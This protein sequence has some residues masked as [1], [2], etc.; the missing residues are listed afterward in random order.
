MAVIWHHTPGNAA[1]WD[2][3]QL[4]RRGHVGVDFFFVLSGFLITTLLLREEG[5]NG[6]I[7]L[8]GFYLR[9]A[10]RIL[11]V[12]FLVV[13][14]AAFNDIILNGERDK[15]EILPY[16][17]LFL[18]N[19]IRGEDITFLAP[20]W[21]LSVEEQYYLIW[22]LLLILLPKRAIV[23]ALIILITWNV[24]SALGLFNLIGVSGISAGRLYFAIGGATYA[25]ILLGSLAAVVLHSRSGFERL[26]PLTSSRLAPWVL[27]VALI[28]SLEFLPPVLEGWPNLIVHGLMTLM[29]V[30]VVVREDNGM[31]TLLRLRPIV[32]IGQISY[33]LYLYHS[34]A[35][36]V[37]APILFDQGIT[38]M[39][40]HLIAFFGLS[41]LVSEISFRT[42]EKWFLDMR[43]KARPA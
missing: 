8:S 10:L 14:A 28:L 25:P 20:T 30:S 11:P 29:L 21:S 16:Y 27:F 18:A 34:F 9:R 13:T 1:Y 36:G 15:I 43:H 32:R 37:T 4:V 39:W 31:N 33:G 42:Y 38:S 40:I 5:Q 3:A 12:Y 17:Y 26:A 23:P 22:P 2:I 41:V 24:A 7:S 19:F 6:R 35:R